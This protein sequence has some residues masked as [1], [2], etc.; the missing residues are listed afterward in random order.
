MKY[1]RTKTIIIYFSFAHR[2]RITASTNFRT[3]L[4]VRASK[5]M[6]GSMNEWIFQHCTP[7][8]AV[9]DKWLCSRP[10]NKSKNGI[11]SA[12]WNALLFGNVSSI[13]FPLYSFCSY[14]SGLLLYLWFFVGV[15]VFL[16]VCV[17]VRWLI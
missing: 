10:Q 6:D 17:L 16:S 3:R 9:I 8:T 14:F 5:W 1:I 11:P 12:L 7:K 4:C 13:D 15:C 2:Q